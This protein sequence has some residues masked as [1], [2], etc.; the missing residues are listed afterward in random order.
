[1]AVEIVMPRL[2]WTAE[3]AV[4]KEWRVRHGDPVAV[5]D[6][7]FSVEGDKAVE[8]IEALDPGILHIPSESPL[9][10]QSAPVGTLLAYIL[11]PGEAPPASG[12]EVS[13]PSADTGPNPN[14]AIAQPLPATPTRR[15]QS[16]IS[17][18]ARKL[19]QTLDL[20]WSHIEGS[21]RTG[22]I[23][24]KDVRAFHQSLLQMSISPV[25]QRLAKE[26]GI[27][28]ATLAQAFPGQRISVDMVRSLATPA[29]VPE[30]T[31]RVVPFS[32]TRQTIADRLSAGRN[33]S[34]P[35]TLMVE[36]DASELVNLRRQLQADG[37]S[38]V[39]SYNVLFMK[40][41]AHALT[42]HPE[43]NAHAEAHALKLFD[44]VNICFAVNAEHGL[45]TP[46]V[47]AVNH[48][49]LEALQQETRELVAQVHANTLPA[50]NMQGGTF[51]LT[52][53]G[54]WQID[55]F[56]P[57]LNPPQV[58]ILGVG[59]IQAKPMVVDADRQE[60]AVRQS[61]TLS[62]TFDHRAVDGVPAAAFLQRIKQFAEQPYLWLT[63]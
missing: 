1:M 45:V 59:R 5:G 11:A 20:D 49:H 42:E 63:L 3:E 15:Q 19:A 12:R 9:P 40:I 46:V 51:T 39:P 23:V 38:A 55:A 17:P 18:R 16:A 57:V 60:I 50:R 4:L 32:R 44:Q 56:T 29:A 31:S 35:V 48:K 22:R 37:R 7:L 41:L 61:L 13:A 14:P 6:V 25:A 34:V 24:E 62:L 52:N 2:G 8:E 47:H 36:M 33:Q 30:T 58:G 26:L 53:L 10:G 27:S 21:G 43:M 54:A 28:A